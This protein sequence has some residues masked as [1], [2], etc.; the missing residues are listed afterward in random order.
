MFL[1]KW[2]YLWVTTCSFRKSE[3]LASSEW[4]AGSA[5]HTCPGKAAHA[6]TQASKLRVCSILKELEAD[7]DVAD[8]MESTRKIQLIEV[9]HTNHDIKRTTNLIS[10]R[11]CLPL[12][13]RACAS[14][15]QSVAKPKAFFL[16]KTTGSGSWLL[17]KPGVDR[18]SPWLK[19]IIC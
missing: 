13:R 3:A 17:G 7:L 14:F 12:R 4:R 5:W 2:K 16:E 19:P 6:H 18:A 1:T 10:R 8:S 11:C 15:R 9:V